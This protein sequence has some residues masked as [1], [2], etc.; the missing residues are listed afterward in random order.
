[1]TVKPILVISDNVYS[2][3]NSKVSLINLIKHNCTNLDMFTFRNISSKGIDQINTDLSKRL[4]EFN[5]L[6]KKTK[7]IA[8]VLCGLNEC[9]GG[10]NV[11]IY[12]T[13]ISSIII[14]LNEINFDVVFINPTIDHGLPGKVG[15]WYKRSNSIILECCEKYYSFCISPKIGIKIF[16]DIISIPIESSR[17]IVKMI[18]D[19]IQSR[20]KNEI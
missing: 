17:I 8:Y 19:D 11:P 9:N 18:C 16:D 3:S 10:Y 13:L 4:N 20:S 1:M 7:G 15:G 12:Q 5:F 2:L 6:S 14:E